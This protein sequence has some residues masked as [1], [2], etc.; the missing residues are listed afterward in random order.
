M[1]ALV[2][3]GITQDF[4]GEIYDEL[5]NPESPKNIVVEPKFIGVKEVID[6]IHGAGGIA[7]LAHPYKYNSV[8]GLDRY[9]EYGIDGIEVWCPSSSEEQQKDMLDYAKSHK[10]LAIGGSDFSGM[11]NRGTV[12]IGDFNTPAADFKA[13]SDYKA[14]LK[15]RAK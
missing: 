1:H 3:C 2:E 12:S 8:P 11:Y 14:M 9:V 15:K 5:F 7:V 10:L 6:A 13:L 4:H